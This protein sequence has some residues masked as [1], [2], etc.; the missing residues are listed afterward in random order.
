MTT[1][2]RSPFSGDSLLLSSPVVSDYT[3]IQT[4]ILSGASKN[5]S[6]YTAYDLKCI[7]NWY[8]E[9]GEAVGVNWLFA[10]AQCLHETAWISSWWSD[11]PRRNPAGI[12]VTG[13]SKTAT[14]TSGKWAYKNGIWLEGVS[15]TSWKEESIPA[16][17]GRMLAYALTDAQADENQLSYITTALSYRTLPLKYRGSVQKLSD[18]NGKWAY[19]G[20]TYGQKIAQLA[21]ELVS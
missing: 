13:S 16:H 12:G 14:P 1:Y 5:N 8:K 15:F 21:T 6:P 3:A 7:L 9:Q 11:R 4:K 17:L 19:P 10:I 18:F 20:T 2:E